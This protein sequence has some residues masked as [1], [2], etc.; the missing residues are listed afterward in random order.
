MDKKPT[1]KRILKIINDTR[2]LLFTK[3][4]NIM[5]EEIPHRYTIDGVEYTPVSN[6]IHKYVP[7]FD[8]QTISENYAK[9]HNL[10]QNDV[11]RE[12][13]WKNRCAIYLGTM[14]HYFGE[15]LTELLSIGKDGIKDD[16]RYRFLEEENWVIPIL[17]QEFAMKKFYDELPENL[18]PVGAEF[19]LSTQYI[20]DA[21]PICG[22]ADILFYYDDPN[23]K[24]SG[25]V[26]GDW[27]TN[28]TLMSDFAQSK[29]Q[30]MLPPFNELIDQALSHYTLQ[31]NI[32]QR[33]FESVGLNVIARRLIHVKNDGEYEVHNIQH[34]DDEKIM[35]A[36]KN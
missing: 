28:K 6:I 19:K 9:K 21:K 1:D 10:S 12:W 2:K 20:K 24:R 7:I 35:F 16:Y 8:E 33:M 30:M 17:Q 26:V 25:F 22:T 15:N 3:F 13:K 36:L 29:G 27:K 4:G 5:F 23:V 11:L 18:Y 14:A 32:Y 31:F 34:L